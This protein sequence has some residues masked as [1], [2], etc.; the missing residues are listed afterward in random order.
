M[1]IVFGELLV[2]DRL[3]TRTQL[4]VALAR[5][6]QTGGRLGDALVAQAL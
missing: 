6:Q 1:S 3:I 4:N 5:Q 2:R